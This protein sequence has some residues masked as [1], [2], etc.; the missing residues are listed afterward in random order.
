[1]SEENKSKW[2]KILFDIA[3]YSL[4]AILGGF[5]VALTGCAFVPVL[6]F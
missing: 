5:G 2:L 4:A 6:D 1:M 3:S